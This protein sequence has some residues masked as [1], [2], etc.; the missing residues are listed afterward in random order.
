MVD[1]PAK[2][3]VVFSK[4]SSSHAI[5]ATILH[6]TF[7][8]RMRISTFLRFLRCVGFLTAVRRPASTE[9]GLAIQGDDGIA[10]HF[11]RVLIFPLVVNQSELSP[12]CFHDFALAGIGAAQSRTG[13]QKK[14]SSTK[15]EQKPLDVCLLK[16]TTV[17]RAKPCSRPDRCYTAHTDPSVGSSPIGAVLKINSTVR[18]NRENPQQL[19][20]FIS[21]SV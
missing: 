8:Q 15:Q 12:A 3:V 4:L 5:T 6:G 17:S 16:K 20:D 11:K 1:S 14:R 7:H 9:A 21:R 2:R 10:G 18:T 13:E 19:A